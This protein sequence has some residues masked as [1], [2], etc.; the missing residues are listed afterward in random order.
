[1]NETKIGKK[2]NFS[3]EEKEEFARLYN[4]G[5][6]LRKIG[7]KFNASK[8]TIKNNIKDLVVFRVKTKA[9]EGDNESRI[10]KMYKEGKSLS[11][12]A[13][14]IGTTS[15]TVKR[16]LGRKG[17]IY[18]DVTS[19]KYAEYLPTI[20]ELAYEGKSLS[21][22]QEKTN[23]GKATLSNYL[24]W[25]NKIPE[26]YYD[27]NRAYM[28]NEDYIT[29]LRETNLYELGV[30]TSTYLVTNRSGTL[31]VDFF[32]SKG[33]FKEHSRVSRHF[34]NKNY[35][36]ATNYKVK[37]MY[38]LSI[39]SS[40]LFKHFKEFDFG[41]IR[42]LTMIEKKEFLRGYIQG[43]ISPSYSR[44]KNRYGEIQYS[45]KFSNKTVFDEFMNYLSDVNNKMYLEI[46][47]LAKNNEKTNS[48][49]FVIYE[50]TY[51]NLLKTFD[52]DIKIEI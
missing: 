12:I 20:I 32:A 27:K 15:D 14:T 5:Y 6:S 9:K 43:C 45:V 44:S 24:N 36:E 41:F 47:S 11:Y 18:V 1:M 51:E 2:R 28:L 52:L 31:G 35:L 34:T 46:S 38:R 4:E 26:D 21:E 37:S 17:L 8:A 42:D 7:E 50:N 22:I 49:S 39:I 29:K 23:I 25:L 40:K 13:A 3:K 19:L 33:F 10:I 16:I 48:V 30:I